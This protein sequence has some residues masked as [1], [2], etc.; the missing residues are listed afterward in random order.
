MPARSLWRAVLG[1]DD[2]ALLGDANRAIDGALGLGEDGV[3]GG[4]TTTAD[5]PAAAVRE[6]KPDAVAVAEFDEGEFGVVKRPVRL[7]ITAVLVGVGVAE[8]DLLDVAAGAQVFAVERQRPEVFEDVGAVRE[9]LDGFKQRDDV[10]ATQADL[11]KQDHGLQN[12]GDGPGH[13]D[14][15]LRDRGLAQVPDGTCGGGE[16]AHFFA[17]DVAKLSLCTQQRARGAQ[18]LDEHLHA[19]LLHKRS[20]VRAHAGN[21]QHFAHDFFEGFG[22][23]AQVKRVQV[24]AEGGHG[25]AQAVQPVVGNNRAAVGAQRG[26]D[27]VQ[28]CEQLAGVGV[29][30]ARACRTGEYLAGGGDAVADAIDGTAVRL[31]DAGLG[32]VVCGV[33]KL[34]KLLRAGGVAV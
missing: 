14:D 25:G 3:V 27:H 22:V 5:C 30:C 11:F 21:T 7:Q 18:L 4:P 6:P 32:G 17:C 13:G 33:R 29:G 1:G 2:L 12:V 26:V 19:V 10:N 31:I 16:D 9:V 34:G 28:V 8:H 23:L 24:E 20:I 15:A